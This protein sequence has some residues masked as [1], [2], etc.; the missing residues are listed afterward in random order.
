VQLAAVLPGPDRPFAELAAEVEELEAAGLDAIVVGEAYT[1]DAVSK[2]GYLAARTEKL[3]VATGIVNVYSRSPAAI[4]QTAAGLDY[5]SG[6]R[7]TLGLGTSGPA[8]IEGF[9]GVAY[10]RPRSRMLDTIEIVRKTL[11]RERLAHQ[12]PTVEIPRGDARPLKLVDHPVRDAVPI[13]WAALLD[14]SVRS[15]AALAD[16]WMPTFFVP[17]AAEAIWGEALAAGLAERAEGLTPLEI[18]S[19][20]RA[21]LAG[22]QQRD[23]LLDQARSHAA[24]Y[25]GGMGPK[26]KNFYTE[27]AVRAG[28]ADAAAEIQSL[29]LEGEREAAAAAV[30]AELLERIHLIGDEGELAAR[31]RAFADA[32]VTTLLVEPVGDDP[33]A[34]V[35]ALRRILDAA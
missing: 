20:G 8:V 5:V 27:I 2:L 15:A 1:F 24:L 19:G 33:V 17:E 34:T 26:G 29:Y 32:G 4:A 31:V 13:W 28:F 21:A 22:P 30:P 25:V 9:H 12:G 6:G 14:R 35:A 10:E 18:V 16:G 3:R 7:F 23:R 11:R